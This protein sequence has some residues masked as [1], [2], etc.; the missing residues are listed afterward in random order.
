[1]LAKRP[2]AVSRVIPH[3]NPE[4]LSLTHEKGTVLYIGDLYE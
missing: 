1:V 3:S 4:V 2:L